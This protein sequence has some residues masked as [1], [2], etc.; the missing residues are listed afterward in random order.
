MPLFGRALDDIIE[1]IEELRYYKRSLF[2]AYSD[3]DKMGQSKSIFQKLPLS[4]PPTTKF[5]TPRLPPLVWIDLET[6]GLAVEKDVILEVAMLITDGE[7]NQI[8]PAES[9]VI[10]Y[11]QEQLDSKLTPWTR[12]HHGQSGLLNQVVQSQVTLDQA[13]QQLLERIKQTTSAATDNSLS[14][15]PLLAGNN[16]GFD[17]KFLEAHMPVLTS[18]LHYRNV[19]VSSLHELGK[20]WAPQVV[21]SFK[22]EYKHR[23]L[24]DIQESLHELK[25]YQKHL[26]QTLVF[27]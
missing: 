17:R 20:R 24:D 9:M 3:L 5:S 19:D 8:A 25:F 21:S 7:L 23:A 22:K 14:S 11:S 6:T 1:S 10:G 2:P 15:L 18:V 16:V 27:F 13:Q 12:N 4:P 26:F